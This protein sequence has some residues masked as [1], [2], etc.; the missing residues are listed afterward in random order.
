M[1]YYMIMMLRQQQLQSPLPSTLI[2]NQSSNQQDI[3][4][5]S[6]EQLLANPEFLQQLLD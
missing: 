2:E 6:E 1:I 4:E 3:P 5:S